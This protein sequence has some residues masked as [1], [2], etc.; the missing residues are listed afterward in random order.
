M[1]IIMTEVDIFQKIHALIPKH[2]NQHDESAV[3]DLNTHPQNTHWNTAYPSQR[4][5]IG[6]KQKHLLKI[7]R[8]YSIESSTRD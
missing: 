4:P 2:V 5:F 1:L 7:H 3:L 6:I 8:S